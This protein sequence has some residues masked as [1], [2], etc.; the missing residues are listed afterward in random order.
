MTSRNV[1]ARI[2]LGD[3]SDVPYTTFTVA[4]FCTAH[5]PSGGKCAGRHSEAVFLHFDPTAPLLEQELCCPPRFVLEKMGYP[6]RAH[7]VR[8]RGVHEALDVYRAWRDKGLSPEYLTSPDFRR[9]VPR[10]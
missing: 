2:I 3:L 5:V 9:E 1:L 8:A 7:A 6:F 4:E 10:D